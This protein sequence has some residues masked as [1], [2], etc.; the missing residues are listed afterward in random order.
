MTLTNTNWWAALTIVLGIA[1]TSLAL[2]GLVL[3]DTGDG[4]Q[5]LALN[6]LVSGVL[7]LAGLVVWR[8]RPVAGSW[9]ILGGGV[10][11][12]YSLLGIP[13]GVVVIATGLWTG[14]LVLNEHSASKLDLS[15]RD[16]S[17]TEHWYRWIMAAVLLGA[18][19]FAVLLIWPAVTPDNCTEF[20]PC[21][22]DT[23]AW[24]TWILSWMAAAATASV[25][26]IL[27]GVRF[28]RHHTRPA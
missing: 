20:N 8:S 9:M 1:A 22:E 3:G 28:T 11:I 25:G 12:A 14:N 5:G 27:A 16:T 23:V 2:L 13:V 17:A 19:G 24:A 15:P 10:L 6:W 18:L 26:V 7:M 4:G 21:W